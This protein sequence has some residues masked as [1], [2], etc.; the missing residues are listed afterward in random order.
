MG[1]FLI[2][3]SVRAAVLQRRDVVEY[4]GHRVQVWE[5]V[6][7]GLATDVAGWLVPRYT[8]AVLVAQCTVALLHL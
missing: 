3:D 2:F 4:E 1:G 8:C 6:V 7:D 5:C